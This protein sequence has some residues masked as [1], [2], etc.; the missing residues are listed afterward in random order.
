MA[1]L[2]RLRRDPTL[3]VKLRIKAWRAVGDNGAIRV[4]LE[5]TTQEGGVAFFV[6]VEL[7]D[8]DGT[9]GGGE[10]SRVL[11]AFYSTNYVV[12]LPGGVAEIDIALGAASPWR[13]EGCR[14]G[15]EVAAELEG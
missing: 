14:R 8:R 11:P 7:R 9:D 5:H 10:A 6:R 13:R 1:G 12:I 3:W 4:R 2:G 15:W